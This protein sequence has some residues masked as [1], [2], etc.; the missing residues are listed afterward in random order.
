MVSQPRQACCWAFSPRSWVFHSSLPEG[1]AWRVELEFALSWDIF[2]ASRFFC[3][4]S[5]CESALSGK[6]ISR[7]CPLKCCTC[8][9]I[10]RGPDPA[11]VFGE[12][13]TKVALRGERWGLLVLPR[14][15]MLICSLEL[16]AP[17][18]RGMEKA[19]GACLSSIGVGWW[20]PIRKG[21]ALYHP[22]Y[23]FI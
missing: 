14:A 3:E 1:Q 10:K 6:L 12:Q 7:H 23:F 17:S 9:A 21:I 11:L 15:A 20:V 4:V 19:W 22:C 18:L 13:W 16:T 8:Q 5:E 2:V